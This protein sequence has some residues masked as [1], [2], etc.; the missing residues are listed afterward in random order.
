MASSS[1]TSRSSRAASS[2]MAAAARPTSSPTAVPSARAS[3]NPAMT[4]SGRA[5]VVA[6]VGQQA[7]LLGP[8]VDELGRHRVEPVGQ[9][10]DLGRPLERERMR[11]T[12]REIGRGG[13]QAPDRAGDGA[14]EQVGDRRPDEQHEEDDERQRPGQVAQ[15]L[16]ARR[17]GLEEDQGSDRTGRVRIAQ[18][19]RRVQVGAAVA[20]RDR[21]G[22]DRPARGGRVDREPD[23]RHRLAAEVDDPPVGA[24]ELDRHAILGDLLAEVGDELPEVAR[25]RRRPKLEH[26]RLAGLGEGGS[27]RLGVERSEGD[28]QRRSDRDQRDHRDRREGQGDPGAEPVDHPVSPGPAR[29][30]GRAGGGGSRGRE[31][32]RSGGRRRPACGGPRRRGRRRSGS[33]PGSPC[34]RRPREACPG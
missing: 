27:G 24:D 13:R 29:V 14:A 20:G 30:R 34:P 7:R 19:G 10:A 26:Q 28:E 31:R 33:R 22:V 15:R 1:P 9:L 11:V 16:G 8:R 2:P 21:P 6:Q 17:V 3:A 12:R 25:Q 23:D 5:Q 4:V 32:S 18:G